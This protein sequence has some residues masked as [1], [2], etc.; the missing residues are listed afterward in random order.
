MAIDRKEL[1][2]R[3]RRIRES[4]A[5]TQEDV[6]ELLGIPRSSVVQ[7]ESGNRSVDSLEFMKLSEE[8]RFDPRGLFAEE[9]SEQNVSVTALFRAEP[10]AAADKN[11]SHAIS[12]MLG[13]CR[14]FKYLVR[15]VGYVCDILSP[16]R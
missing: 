12:K 13:L 9:F 11:L 7:I 4:R 1:G 14:L 16:L 8:L 3:L 5:Y 15:L 6:A 2:S 10:R